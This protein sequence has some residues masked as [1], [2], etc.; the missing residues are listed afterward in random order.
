MIKVRFGNIYSKLKIFG[1]HIQINVKGMLLP[2]RMKHTPIRHCFSKCV[3]YSFKV[4]KDVLS[5]KHCIFYS[6]KVALVDLL[7]HPQFSY[8]EQFCRTITWSTA[9]M[10]NTYKFEKVLNVN[11]S[12]KWIIC[13]GL[14]S[15][16]SSL[17]SIKYCLVVRR[18]NYFRFTALIN[19]S[20]L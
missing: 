14:T 17:V 9:L 18:G 11:N 15:G 13:Y 2:S 12:E 20:G 16:L 4:N 6:T 19:T 1:E 3:T 7:P 10:Q 8:D 5:S